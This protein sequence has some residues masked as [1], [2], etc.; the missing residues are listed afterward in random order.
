MV[1]ISSEIIGKSVKITELKKL[2][3]IIAVSNSPVLIYGQ[4]GSGKELVAQR[5]HE[6]SRRKGRFIA[7]N[8]AAI[9]A[10]LM[11][12]E[13]FGFEKGAFTGAIKS[14]PGKF[15]QAH[16][17]TLFLDELGDMPLTLQSKILRLLET[18]SLTKVGSTKEQKFNTRVVCA[19][20]KDLEELVKNK[21]FR[22]DLFFR[23]NVFPLTVPSLN[24]RREDVPE[25]LE[26]FLKQRT[27]PGAP[28]LPIFKSDAVKM[29]QSYNWPGNIREMRNL[30]ERAV[31]FFPGQNISKNDVE[32]YLIRI[33]ASI[34]SRAEEQNAIW[35]EF[36]EL[37]ANKISVEELA[38]DNSKLPEPNDFARWFDFY[39]SI[40]L[41]SMLRD[42]EIVLI[43]AS[44]NRNDNNTSEAAKDLKLLRTTLIEKIKK[45][46]I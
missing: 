16:N 29:L 14:T 37:S 39:N 33:D 35:D 28:N 21:Q 24:E 7:L 41:R 36:E 11:E 44:L 18:S 8:C 6:E 31:T 19:T 13:L 2:I 4:T 17:G 20:H 46:G 9:P 1:N 42:I 22:E 23:L 10:E 34:I 25:L 26:H 27:K 3:S 12:A 38:S 40:D 5:L 45:Y 43:Q 15:E 32:K 30:V